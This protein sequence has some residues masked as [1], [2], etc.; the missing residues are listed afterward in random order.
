M[1]ESLIMQIHYG[2]AIAS[3]S[4][5]A[6]HIL[7]RFTQK[8]DESLQ[9]DNVLTNYSFL[10]YALLLEAILIL[11][12]VHGFNGLRII[13][14]EFKQGAIYEKLV[15]YSC[16]ISMVILITY[17]TRTILLTSIGMI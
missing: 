14:L 13:L 5:V 11:I 17:G 15:T 2:T 4:L 1:R 16:L 6:M 9:F 12:T 7:L 8:F 10:P 3:V